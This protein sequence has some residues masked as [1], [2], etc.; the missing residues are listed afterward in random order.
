M[1]TRARVRSGSG[2]GGGAAWSDVS[3]A[4]VGGRL[5]LLRRRAL[6][7]SSPLFTTLSIVFTCLL[8]LLHN[9]M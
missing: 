9:N 3:G 2:P 8:H 1:I 7:G 6:L 4:T 5:T